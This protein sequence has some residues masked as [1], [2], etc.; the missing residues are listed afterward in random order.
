MHCKTNSL[1]KIKKKRKKK[2]S[3]RVIQ[4]EVKKNETNNAQHALTD[5][6]D[7]CVFVHFSLHCHY[8]FGIVSAFCFMCLCL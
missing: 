4:G 5:R 8:Q 1:F 2:R 7:E 3:K 6:H